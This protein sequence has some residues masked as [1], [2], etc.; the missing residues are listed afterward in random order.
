MTLTD[1]LRSRKLLQDHH[2]ANA[3]ADSEN[4]CSLVGSWGH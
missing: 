4:V 1:Y 3:A 2:L